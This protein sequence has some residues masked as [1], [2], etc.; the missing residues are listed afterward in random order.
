MQA[1]HLGVLLASVLLLVGCA[2]T[3]QQQWQLADGG[4]YSGAI[5]PDGQSAAIGSIFHGGSLWRIAE[6]TRDFDWNLDV[7]RQIG[8]YSAFT[9]MAFSGDGE[10]V[11]SVQ[12]RRVVS[13]SASRG[14]A[15]DF[16][17]APA[18]IRS[19]AMNHTG[20]RLLLGLEDGTVAVFA[21]GTG[22]MVQRLDGHQ[23]PVHAAFLSANGEFALTGGDDQQAILWQVSTGRIL[24]RVQHE[25]R[26]RTVALSGNGSYAL[27]AAQ[28]DDG[29]V[30][31]TG[32]G[33]VVRTIP[34]RG[35]VLSAA[36]FIDNDR[37]LLV[38]DRRH[39]VSQ[40]Q[41]TDVSRS[42]YWRLD[43]VGL[44]ARTS[45]VVLDVRRVDGGV[46]ALSSNGKL[47]LLQ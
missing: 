42:G 23:G 46:L 18:V 9:D 29:W 38:G 45:N 34:A 44:Y 4:L 47:A 35:R 25:H 40:W 26:V 37:A 13:W 41:L 33:R 22:S 14:A 11:A 20:D 32:N 12:G 7:D 17:E 30:W 31:D 3:P 16:F 15:L 21:S 6:F 28:G 19:I 43:G 2:D 36:R 24:Q 27:S 8:N 10:R 1:R 39:Y 5:A